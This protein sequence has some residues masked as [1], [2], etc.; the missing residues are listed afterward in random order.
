MG[1][2][3]GGLSGEEFEAVSWKGRSLGVKR[4]PT[5]L[6]PLIIRGLRDPL[7][8]VKSGFPANRSQ[9]AASGPELV[10]FL[11]PLIPIKPGQ[12]KFKSAVKIEGSWFISFWQREINYIVYGSSLGYSI[13][14]G[15]RIQSV[16]AVL[17]PDIPVPE[18]MLVSRE[19]ALEKAK[20]GIKDFRRKKYRLVAEN[21]LIFPDREARPIRYYQ[22]YAFNF[23][24][25]E[26]ARHPG[27]AEA[28]VGFFVDTQTGNIVD[29]QTLFKPLGCCLPEKGPPLD[30]RELYKSQIGK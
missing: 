12:L 22:V 14:K 21:I 20:S 27:E 1:L 17:Y 8:T 10:A 15:G 4:D 29:R 13:D 5:T 18:K 24:I 16:G 26:K 2:F 25:P 23:F 30:T 9:A 3:P 6:S 19:Q 7:L 28:G 11:E